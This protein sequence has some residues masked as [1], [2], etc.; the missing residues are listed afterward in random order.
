[1]QLYCRGFD[2]R[3]RRFSSFSLSKHGAAWELRIN[4]REI[5]IIILAKPS[6]R[7]NAARRARYGHIF[8]LFKPTPPGLFLGFLIA[9][10]LPTMLNNL[11]IPIYDKA[12]FA[13]G[14]F[15]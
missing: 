10:L 14:L 6:V 5:I 2:S 7:Q 9:K 4:R 1:M 12:V 15:R 3:E 8:V 13:S 11:N